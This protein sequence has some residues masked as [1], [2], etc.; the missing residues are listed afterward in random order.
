M[1]F[2][3]EIRHEQA[4]TGI[5]GSTCAHVQEPASG[6]GEN[7]PAIQKPQFQLLALPQRLGKDDGHQVIPSSG[8]LGAI[9]R[10]IV[11]ELHG[12]AANVHFFDLQEARK[13]KVEGSLTALSDFH[14]ERCFGRD[15]GR[16]FDFYCNLVA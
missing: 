10:R 15:G 6:F 7:L 9:H 4:A 13:L 1:K 12:M 3:I 2:Q 8:E 16:R 11:D 14:L 5:P